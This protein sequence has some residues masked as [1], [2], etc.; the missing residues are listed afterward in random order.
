MG[1][2]TIWSHIIIY[3]RIGVFKIFFRNMFCKSLEVYKM[4]Y[5]LKLLKWYYLNNLTIHQLL[6]KC[7]G[8][9]KS[10]PELITFKRNNSQK[11][12][13]NFLGECWFFAKNLTN[14]THRSQNSITEPM[15]VYTKGG[16]ISEIPK[17]SPYRFHFGRDLAPIFGDVSQSERI[18]EIKQPL[19]L[20]LSKHLVVL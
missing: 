19:R 7:Q 20:V 13:D 4:H 8:K 9:K 2:N 5:T 12:S 16:L 6:N 1:P 15:L 18:S 10:S 11:G 14:L 3:I 17:L